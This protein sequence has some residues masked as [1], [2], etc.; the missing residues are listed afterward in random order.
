MV[1]GSD[2]ESQSESDEGGQK[3]INL[4]LDLDMTLIFSSPIKPDTIEEHCM[5]LVSIFKK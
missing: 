4:V 3:K 5:V 2:Y 1:N